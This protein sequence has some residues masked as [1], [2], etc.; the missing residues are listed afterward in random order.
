MLKKVI[1]GFLLVTMLFSNQVQ[2]V[3]AE[4]VGTPTAETEVLEHKISSLVV[5]KSN[6]SVNET[7]DVIVTFNQE[8]SLNEKVILHYY[9]LT[10]QT[11]FT[12]ENG[13]IEGT[14]VKFSFPIKDKGQYQINQLDIVKD[15]TVTSFKMTEIGI[16]AK[17]GV[18][19]IVETSPDY[20]LVDKEAVEVQTIQMSS[21]LPKLNAQALNKP[22]VVVL[23][24]GHGGSDPGAVRSYSGVD[25]AERD[26][27]LKIANACE[28]ELLAYSNIKVYM[29]RRDNSSVNLNRSERIAYAKS[30]GANVV[31]SL[32]LNATGT[33]T[34]TATG[35]EVYVPNANYRPEIGAEA[36]A[37]GN[38]ILQTLVSNGIVNRGTKFFTCTD[39]VY[40]DGS[41]ADNYGINYYAKLEGFPGIIVEHCYLSNPSDFEKYLNT[42]AKLKQLGIADATGIANYY[43]LSKLKINVAEYVTYVGLSSQFAV[44]LSG[45]HV[46][47]SSLEWT[48]SDTAV[49]TIDQNGSIQAKSKGT[50]VISCKNE[51]G[52]VATCQVT[53]N[54]RLQVNTNSYA[55]YQ[56]QSSSFSVA[57]N[58][59]AIDNTQ[60]RWTTSN[61]NIANIDH[62]GVVT[63]VNPGKAEITVYQESTNVKDVVHVEVLPLKTVTLNIA[64]YNCYAGTRSGFAAYVNGNIVNNN[65][66]QWKS[67][68]E[69]IA[70]VDQYGVVRGISGGVTTIECTTSFG[71]IARCKVTVVD[72]LNINTSYYACYAGQKSGFAAE[73]NGVTIEN[74]D[75]YWSSSNPKVAAIQQDGSIEGI[76]QGKA[77]ISIRHK[78]NNLTSQCV[79]EILPKRQVTINTNEYTCNV[80]MK[81][82]FAAYI[83]GVLVDNSKVKWSS[84]N[85]QVARIDEYG[86]VYGLK[87]GQATIYCT[88][89]Y[90][91]VSTCVVTVRS[92]LKINTN[93]YA[94]YP[95]QKSTFAVM[96]DGK[97]LANSEVIWTSS[98][99]SIA[100]IDANGN[101]TGVN[102]GKALITAIEPTTK[103]RSDCLVEVLNKKI[104]TMNTNEYTFYVGMKSGFAGYIDGRLV[105]NS[106]MQWSSS[107][108]AVAAI[109][110]EGVITG[111]SSG[112]TTIYCT[113]K[114]GTVAQCKVIVMDR[115]LIN[116]NY[117]ECYPTQKS[118][119][120]VTFNNTQIANSNFIWSSSNP[121]VAT[122]DGDGNIVGVT[123]GLSTITVTSKSSGISA[124]CSVRIL[125]KKIV[126]INTNS[127]ECFV[128]TKTGFA[129][130]SD[131]Y[132]RPANSFTWSSSDSSI[133]TVNEYGVI[134]TL[135]P[136]T[137]FIRCTTQYGTTDECKI[138]VLGTNISGT[139]IAT[140]QQM[141]AY[142]MSKVQYYPAKNYPTFYQNSDAA[143]VLQFCEIFLDEGRREG[144]RGDLAFCQ[145]M[146]ETGFLQLFGSVP[147]QN[148][149]FAGLGA[150]GTADAPIAAFP[151]VRIGIRAQIQHLKA[152]ATPRSVP[153]NEA[154]VD[155]R[156][157]LVKRGV[158]PF[159]E[160]LGQ[161]ENPQGYGWATGKNYGYSIMRIYRE[162][163]KFY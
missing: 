94:C 118:S 46:P 53:V 49:A 158:A 155:P 5:S 160:W 97:E 48:S 129:A 83:D 13:L 33:T 143:T 36:T 96:L 151:S 35:A 133:I 63:G 70:T 29:T 71:T 139:S 50:C 161:Q 30:V 147:I 56:G 85:E 99:N 126:K 159:I 80:G 105:D 21:A 66:M 111:K 51:S 92:A 61:T 16:D 76:S 23:D 3:Y 34:T 140:A 40:P 109:N 68:N 59:T 12:Q 93:S 10:S 19:E 64:D 67:L 26:L 114:Y 88:A 149:N 148:Y 15:G 11:E 86:V 116:T 43:N 135:K 69:K 72:R 57:L 137:A 27:V 31:V 115:I 154:G 98:N 145:A 2:N 120:A 4:T 38:Q 95:S 32:H 82:G 8:I 79:V 100:T 91:T 136:G 45:N 7:Q 58:G 150:T 25:Y 1:A 42:D 20:I 107:N 78:K 17:F 84:S 55:C 123:P 74:S 106:F 28:Q 41:K 14:S 9:D 122:I 60:V 162:L 130:T 157:A 141:A 142:Y 144:I 39:T 89:N 37:L 153:I 128:G 131:G 138:T 152:Y 22:L 54:D 110:S 132:D 18:G 47:N 104:V 52:A 77:I 156:F 112:V 73:L 163:T 44:T 65:T 62:N 87:G 127:F 81:S 124:Q 24:P 102:P 134:D 113:T 119:F 125:N 103:T 75:V 90:G 101:I 108:D 6:V 121:S 146:L 117:Y